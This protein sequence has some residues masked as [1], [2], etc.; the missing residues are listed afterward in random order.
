MPATAEG[1]A[2]GGLAAAANGGAQNASVNAG[3]AAQATAT[4]PARYAD[5]LDDRQRASY[6]LNIQTFKLRQQHA[7]KVTSDIRVIDNAIKSSARMYILDDMMTATVRETIQA[8]AR[9]YKRTKNQI[10][11]QLHIQFLSLKNAPAKDK[12]EQ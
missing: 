1:A 3:G 4:Q 2:V 10:I 7:E 8:L 12:I 6:Q 5:E 11:E 9:K